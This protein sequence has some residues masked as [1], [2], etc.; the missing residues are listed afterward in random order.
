MREL[1]AGLEDALSG[2][3]RL[4]L[5]GGEP[6]IGKS[7]LADELATL[8][9]ER[10]ARV[11][12]GRCWEAGGA[13]AYW[14]WV[15]SIRSYMRDCDPETLVA[16]LG[17][18]ASDLAQVFPELREIITDLSAPPSLDPEGARFRLFDSTSRFLINASKVQPLVFVLDDLHAADTPSLVLL[19]FL[20]SQLADA[21]ILIVGAYRDEDVERDQALTETLAELGREQVTR[22]IRL[23]GLSQ[24]AVAQFIDATAGV[25]PPE[26]LVV[27]VHNETEGNP[28]FVAEVI[29]FLAAEGQ[30]R[31]SVGSPPTRVVIPPRIREVIGRR[32]GR[33][34]EDC[35]RILTLASVLG[36]EFDLVAL[37]RASKLSPPELLEVLE[38]P[39]TA[40][41]VTQVP[42]TLGRLRFSHALVRD[43]LYDGLTSL[44]RVQL[45]RQIGEMLEALYED[46]AEPHL[47][48]LAHHFIEAAPGGDV[49]KAVT[50]T[51]RAGDR[52]MSLLAYEE[53]V[54]LYHLALQALELRGSVDDDDRCEL[55]LALGDAQT[56]VGD[57]AAAKRSLLQAA[58]IANR[59]KMPERL[60]RAALGYGGRFVWARS[61]DDPRLVLLLEDALAALGEEDSPLHAKLL[62]RLAGALRDRPSRE[63]RASLSQRAVE[64]ARRIGDPATLA[65]ALDGRYA[66]VWWSGN[67]EERLA[68]ASEIIQLSDEVGDKERAAQGHDYRFCALMELGDI[69]AVDAELEVVT[70]LAEE[71]RQPAQ[72]WIATQ[73]H[74]MR[75]LLDGRFEEAE[76]LIHEALEVGRGAQGWDAGVTFTL[77]MFVLCR[78]QGR[79]QEIEATIRHAVDEYPTRPMFRCL[80]AS[81][82]SELGRKAEAQR[83]FE[84]LSADDFARLSAN[85][86]DWLFGMT[87]LSEVAAFLADVPRA[88]TL[89]GLMLPYA[90][91]VASDPGEVSTGSASRY[92]G[93]LATT[94]SRFDEAERHFDAALAMNTRMGAR[95]WIAHTQYDYAEMLLA[96]DRSGDREKAFFLAS[97][98]FAICTAIGMVALQGKVSRLLEGQELSVD[99]PGGR[100][101]E[102][103]PGLVVGPSVFRREGEYWS[104]GYEGEMFRL[105][106]SKGL[107]YIAYLLRDPGR[108]FH[109]IDLVSAGE[110]VEADAL[111]RRMPG[112]RHAEPGL[113]VPGGDAGSLLDPQAKAAYRRRLAE[114]E[115]ELEEAEVWG[116]PERAARAKEELDFL[117]REL[118]GGMGLGG[119]DRKAASAAEQARINVTKAIRSAL[120][121][122]RKNSSALGLHLDRTIRTGAFCSYAPDPRSAVPWQL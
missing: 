110:G 26:S 106:D 3:G 22:N 89:Y 79:L 84:D 69:A 32:L 112:R 94:V 77:Q 103:S 52:A 28:L 113:H 49:D 60:A 35:T 25:A 102:P 42:G 93:I 116:D 23:L 11:L 65:Y 67:A 6:G 91:Y 114:L 17:G 53:A 81:L 31:A 47:A 10:G 44:R 5:I 12:W 46:N 41:V 90:G 50:Y 70:R 34:S 14:P 15:Q 107:R 73:T 51:W 30:L 19:R 120:A 4:F 8:A 45:H 36:R 61:G 104:I 66:A 64:M 33:L 74:A 121:R 108:E 68:I 63:P 55:L 99:R 97:D 119:R 105:K 7:R 43:V 21:H 87:F 111:S 83:T 101:D 86:N 56:R 118:A 48:E 98:A 122:I 59:R 13:P 40:R 85:G 117:T 2:R 82:D 100:A 27:A 20:A 29:G 75:A 37:E 24:P 109:V 58:D 96:R 88:A 115:G 72:R 9:K 76:E 71:L 1:E 18:G 16:Q 95:P 38:E 92:V 54:R 62:A 80:L 57:A 78:E 39:V